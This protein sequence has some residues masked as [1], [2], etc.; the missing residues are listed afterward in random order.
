M[1]LPARICLNIISSFLRLQKMGL[2]PKFQQIS[3]THKKRRC[4]KA[5]F[6]LNWRTEWDSNPR[7]P[8]GVHTISNRAPSASRSSVRA[9]DMYNVF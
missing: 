3:Q 9:G 4:Y 5:S 1:E 6:Q 7:Y 8:L 2:T